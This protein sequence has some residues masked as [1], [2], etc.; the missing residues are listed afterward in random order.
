MPL[1]RP[2]SLQS[3]VCATNTPIVM[4]SCERVL[5][6]AAAAFSRPS[7]SLGLSAIMNRIEVTTVSRTN[8]E[9][10]FKF[11]NNSGTR[12]AGFNTTQLP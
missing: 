6:I 1:A 3:I 10:E 9:S 7:I 12:S 11:L 5:P 4:F 8:D 2:G